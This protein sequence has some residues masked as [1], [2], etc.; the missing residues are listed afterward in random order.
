MSVGYAQRQRDTVTVPKTAGFRPD[1]QGLRA[2]AVLAVV[3]DHLLEYPDGGFVGVDVFFVIS[4]FLI[5][6]LLLREHDRTGTISFKGFYVRRVKRIL[7]AS[8]L[9]LLTTGVS[10]YFLLGGDRF[11]LTAK[12]ILASVLFAA[13]WRF[14]IQ[15]T[16][17]FQEGQPPSPVQHFW[18]LAVEEQYYLFWPWLMLGLLALGV[19]Y[20]AW[21]GRQRRVAVGVAIGA[22]TVVSFLWAFRETAS[23]PT[24]AYFSTLSRTWEL[25]VGALLAVLGNAVAIRS[26]AVRAVLGWIGLAGILVSLFVVPPSPGFPA[27]WGALPVLATA[28]VIAAG[29]GGEQRYLW[30]LTNRV[31]RYVGDV[32]YSLYLWH[33]PVVI[34]L[35]AVLPTDSARYYVVALVL[36]AVLSVSSYHLVEDPI[37][38]SSWLTSRP[39]VPGARLGLR[40]GLAAAMIVT[41]VT[42]TVVVHGWSTESP[43][44]GPT[45]AEQRCLGAAAMDPALGCGPVAGN[46]VLP[47]P[48]A[49]AKDTAGAFDCWIDE[50]APMKVCSDGQPGAAR[51][52][53]LLGDS[54]AAMLL[55]GLRA[56]LDAYGWRL[57][58]YTGWGCQWMRTGTGSTCDA[59][60][61]DIQERLVNGPK[62]DIAIVTGARHKTAKDKDWVSRMYAEA[63]RP[64]AARGTK[65]VV[66]ADNPGVPPSALQCVQRV[67]FS[68]REND[69]VIP[70]EDAYAEVDAL[71]AAAAMV[72]GVGLVDLRPFYCDDT[73][74]P[75]VIGNVIAYRDTV[76]HITGTF[77]K[78]LGPY[79]VKAIDTAAAG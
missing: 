8:L 56:Q 52:V 65:I 23:E 48:A 32:S 45:A 58:S 53:A 46:F 50:G 2:V 57:D 38:R 33:F 36:M 63:W 51:S 20:L 59:A 27:P 64:V 35:A 70:V 16:D 6:S 41:S 15:G 24:V 60:M 31:S 5:T 29:Q 69:C 74:C 11:T 79:L 18:S 39:L 12:D 14:A 30:P 9:V 78:T 49:M 77:S 75:V 22:V 67:G 26:A 66:I 47:A 21:N 71:V 44:A 61:K 25:G 43:A 62:Y 19:R 17:Y 68:V 10:S 28:L 1:V 34:L 42:A 13:N 4:G 73:S 37:R 54:H 72:D 76:G 3:A 40:P 7:P 55:P